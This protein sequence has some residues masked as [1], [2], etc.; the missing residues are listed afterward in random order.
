MAKRGGKPGLPDRPVRLLQQVVSG[1]IAA[2][3]RF[4]ELSAGFLYSVAWRYARGDPDRAADLVVVALEGLRKPDA[5]GRPFYRLRRY[6]ESLERFGRRSR[7]ITW[8]ALVVKNL[9]RDWFREQEGRRWLPKEIGQ[10]DLKA[11]AL[12]RALLWEGLDEVDAMQRLRSRWP[13]L[14]EEACSDLLLQIFQVLSSQKLWTL[15]QDLL[16]RQPALPVDGTGGSR[17]V[18]VQIAARDPRWRPDRAL[19]IKLLAARAARIGQA[20]A[21]AVQ[22]L[23]SVQQ[24]VVQLLALRGL[25]GEEVRRLMGF[26]KRQ[27][28][29]DEM[30]KARRQLGAALIEAGVSPDE[31]GEVTGFVDT[32]LGAEKEPS[33]ARSA[34][35][36]RREHVDPAS[37]ASEEV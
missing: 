8:L 35:A 25:S 2:W 28:V 34:P 33:N 14:D 10:L 19:E 37:T 32:V 27:K 16:R 22:S 1:D 11:Q 6:L 9:F 21:L 29:Y 26:T 17:G 12:F 18:A 30:A 24:Q 20:L 3:H 31:I 13:D 5:E 7:F 23:P 4:V 15:Y 36:V